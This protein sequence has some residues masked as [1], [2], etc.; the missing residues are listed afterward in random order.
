[1]SLPPIVEQGLGIGLHRGNRVRPAPVSVSGNW[2][3]LSRFGN[4]DALP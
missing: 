2:L 1:M 3:T 4:P